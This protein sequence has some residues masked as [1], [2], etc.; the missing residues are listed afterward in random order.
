MNDEENTPPL[1]DADMQELLAHLK[2]AEGESAESILA[3]SASFEL[4][5]RTH[6]ALA[7]MPMVE[8]LTDIVPAVLKFLR[9]ML[10]FSIPEDGPQ[11]PGAD[12]EARK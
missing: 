12:G 3:S 8:N 1:D 2:E 7:Q 6:P 4:W 9:A 11:E 10:G 5:L